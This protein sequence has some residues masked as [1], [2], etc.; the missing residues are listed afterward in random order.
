[1]VSQEHYDEASKQALGFSSNALVPV[2]MS[3]MSKALYVSFSHK[4]LCPENMVS[5]VNKPY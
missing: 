5:H 3:H 4:H 2:Y 1:M